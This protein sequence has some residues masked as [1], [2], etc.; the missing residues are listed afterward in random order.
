[1]SSKHKTF[2]VVWLMLSAYIIAM[3]I[4]HSIYSEARIEGLEENLTELIERLADTNESVAYE[5][6]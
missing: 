6:K 5:G 3:S 4:G 2:L 1:M